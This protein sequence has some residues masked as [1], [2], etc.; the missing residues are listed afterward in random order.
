[1]TLLAQSTPDISS[2]PADFVKFF[3][4]MMGFAVVIGLQIYNSVFRGP[5]KR[6]VTGSI[7]HEEVP[8]FA[9]AED[10]EAL[11]H[12]V[13]Q[14]KSTLGA[15]IAEMQQNFAA[16]LH[17]LGKETLEGMGEIKVM[18]SKH[19]TMLD[20]MEKRLSALEKSHSESVTRLHSRIDDAMKRK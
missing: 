15:R 19:D 7:V 3:C 18:A 2:V 11:R 5:Q 10:V 16:R 13:Q 20:Q 1:M 14:D 12:D 17:D 6:E 4:I 8:D 9:D